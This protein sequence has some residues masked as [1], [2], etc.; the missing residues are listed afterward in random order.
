ME[1]TISGE[2][3]KLVKAKS[4]GSPEELMRNLTKKTLCDSES[5]VRGKKINRIID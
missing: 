2:A 5:S 1:K 3:C 4:D